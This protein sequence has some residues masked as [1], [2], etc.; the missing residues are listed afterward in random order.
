MQDIKLAL[1]YGLL[2]LVVGGI[3]LYGSA[4]IIYGSMPPETMFSPLP[5]WAILPA[6]LIMPFSIAIV[7]APLY[8]GYALPRLQSL[9]NSKSLAIII[10]S[11]ALACQHIVL[12]LIFDWDFM[13]WRLFSF[14]PVALLLAIIFLKTKRLFP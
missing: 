1:F 12:P 8:M 11:F 10:T 13:L 14:I 4:Y 6:L 5:M 3:G 2:G 7:E 9:L